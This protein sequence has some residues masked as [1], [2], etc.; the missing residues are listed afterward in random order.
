MRL[1][2]TA[3]VLALAACSTDA[4][5]DNAAQLATEQVAPPRVPAA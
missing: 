1:L 4:T 3:A 5:D 2:A